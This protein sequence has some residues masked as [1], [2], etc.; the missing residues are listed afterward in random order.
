MPHLKVNRTAGARREVTY[1]GVSKSEISE[2]NER[3]MARARRRKRALV[4]E[5]QRLAQL[6]AAADW[7]A[8]SRR[9]QQLH[10]AW[11]ALG[12]AG[13]RADARLY[14]RF[15]AA[16]S[17]FHDRRRVHLIQQRSHRPHEISAGAEGD[18]APDV[19]VDER[20]LE[21]RIDQHRVAIAKLDELRREYVQRCQ[22]MSSRA[23]DLR[24]IGELNR[25]IE[26]IDEQLARRRQWLLRDLS[27]VAS[28]AT[29]EQSQSGVRR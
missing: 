26:M 3:R 22:Q 23:V 28:L 20:R 9:M 6:D 15:S 11:K 8:A 14:E 19:A 25:R 5:A 12:S 1:L 27:H 13:Q 4:R 2:H 10:R 29:L 7:Y 16:C 24:M 18:R 17:R 21:D